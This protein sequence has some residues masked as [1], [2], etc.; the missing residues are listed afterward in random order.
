MKKVVGQKVKKV[1][2]IEKVIGKAKFA[3]DYSFDDMLYLKILRAPHPHAKIIDIDISKAQELDG[4]VRI[5]TAD[6]LPELNNFGLILKDEEVFV[7]EKTHYMGDALAAIAAE[8][9]EIAHEARNLI[10][11][12]YE[13]LE[14]IDNPFRA[15]ED[16]APKI[17]EEGNV[18]CSHN[19][20]KGDVEQGFEEADL[21]ISNEFQTQHI[22]QLPLEPEAGVAKYDSETDTYTLWAPTQWLHDTQGDMAQS[23][24]VPPE[25]IKINQPTIGGAF[26]KREDIS[27]HLHLAIMAK[28]T[29]KPVKLAYT[30]E[31]S[32]ITQSKRHPITFK[33]KTGVTKDGE[34]IAWESEVIGDTGAC[35]SSGPAVV[36]QA[37]YHC[38]GPY[39]VPNV[40]G[41]S[42]TVYTNNTYAGAMRG[43]GATQSAFAYES[44]IDIIAEE[45]GMD[46]YEF[47][48]KN[49]YDIGSSTPNG[50]IL[51]SSV[52][53]KESLKKAIEAADYQK[54]SASTEE[55]ADNSSTKKCGKGMATIMFGNGYGEGFPDHSFC[56]VKVK[57]DGDILIE[58]AAADVGQGVLTVVTQIVSEVLNISQDRIEVA[59][60]TTEDMKN[61]GSTSASRQTIFSGNAAKV[62]AEELLGQINHQAFMELGANYPEFEVKDGK[63]V[64][65]EGEELTFKELAQIAKN[66]G[67]PLKAEGCYFPETYAPDEETG[68]SEL[69][70]VTYT[71]NTHVAEV[72]VDTDTGIVTVLRMVTAP[73]VGKAIHPQNIEGQSEGGTVM[74]M[75]MALME[76]Q[77]IDEG[78]TMNPNMSNYLVPT[79]MDVPEIETVIVESGDGPGPYGAKGIGEPVTLPAAPA[80]INAI[81]DAIGVRIKELP[82]TPEKILKALREKND[83]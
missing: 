37:L 12:E 55:K 60:G 50:Q 83:N 44:Q 65:F 43:F 70:Y 11:V 28:L 47:R 78:I 4:V 33:F 80:I 26:G 10:E 82:A 51:T 67:E 6:D 77:I 32:M 16:D 35:A 52:G 68:Y 36:H 20:E 54:K 17:H 13:E 18:V 22:E 76:D 41:K 62:A 42:Y 38:T 1:D 40:K 29:G 66:K 34:I 15:M 19:L 24:G 7:K 81:E 71:F 57:E 5:V 23:L 58:T 27:V 75:G 63:V 3:K 2:A 14:V 53:A 72:E 30:R 8:S 46:P 45:L 73:D 48:L 31:E 9:E 25:K 64:P 21:I 79:T 56:T 69:A 49:A 74:G 59:P 61:A 39:N